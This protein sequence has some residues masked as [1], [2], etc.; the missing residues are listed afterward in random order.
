VNN[1]LYEVT[2]ELERSRYMH[3][4]VSGK[5]SKVERELTSKDTEIRRLTDLLTVVENRGRT[6]ERELERTINER[7]LGST[8]QIRE[9]KSNF[10][11]KYELEQKT[12][13]DLRVQ[14]DQLNKT[15]RTLTEENQHLRVINKTSEERI[16]K[17]ETL[18]QENAER[19]NSL[20]MKYDSFFSKADQEGFNKEVKLVR[21]REEL[22]S[23]K[24]E[25][26]Q[27]EKLIFQYQNFLK[28]HNLDYE[29]TTLTRLPVGNFSKIT[30]DVKHEARE[31][32]AREYYLEQEAMKNN[33]LV[34]EKEK[35]FGLENQRKMDQY[36]KEM[37]NISDHM[38][39]E[40]RKLFSNLAEFKTKIY[41]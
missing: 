29:F 25:K 17:L 24:I 3:E 15:V 11:L 41:S 28:L 13:Q 35:G 22:E 39:D 33:A 26:E 36:R 31:K 20:K 27:H 4:D 9:E 14:V 34:K 38:E 19:F 21:C 10:E 18:E 5:S 30:T 37:D 7:V 8:H 2:R 23:L 40:W 32:A 1:K 6:E 16:T 12:N